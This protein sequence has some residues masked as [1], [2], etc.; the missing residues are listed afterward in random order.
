[1][2]SVKMAGMLLAAFVAGSFVASPELRAYAANTVFSTDIKDGEV[3]TPDLGNNAVTSAKI[4]DS[5]VKAADIAA[6]AVGSSEIATNAVGAEEI[7]FDSVGASEIKGVDKLIFADCILPKA[8]TSSLP[9]SNIGLTCQVAGVDPEDEVI[10]SDKFIDCFSL[11]GAK[12]GSADMRLFF[13]NV[14]ISSSTFPGA[15]V[16]VI[17]YDELPDKVPPG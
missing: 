7:V 10:V 8:S 12:T 17:V 13:R 2:I 9:D 14:C 5:E 15:R 16:S 4:K 3:K 1:M 11:I 6:D